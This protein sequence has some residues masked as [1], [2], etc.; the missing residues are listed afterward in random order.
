MRDVV[1]GVLLEACG[2]GLEVRELV[3]EAFRSESI[4]ERVEARHACLVWHRCYLTA[5]AL[6]GHSGAQPNSIVCPVGQQD[7]AYADRAQQIWALRRSWARTGVSANMI[8]LNWPQTKMSAAHSQGG[9]GAAA[10]AS[11]RAVWAATTSSRQ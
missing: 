4:K 7:V 3:E 10:D 9:G 1:V 11:R 6:C 5:P 2:G 8:G